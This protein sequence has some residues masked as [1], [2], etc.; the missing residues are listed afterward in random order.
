V[1]SGKN[2]PSKPMIPNPQTG[3]DITFIEMPLG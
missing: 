2:Y 1:I 3:H